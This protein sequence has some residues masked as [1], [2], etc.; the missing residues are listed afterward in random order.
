MQKYI[1]ILKKLVLWAIILAVLAL[2]VFYFAQDF[3]TFPGRG[4]YAGNPGEWQTRVGSLGY[5]GFIP[6]DFLGAGGHA[7][8]GIWAPCGPTPGPAILWLHSREQTTTEINQNIKPL[9]QAGLHVFAM[10]FRGYGAST[11]ETKEANLLADGETSIEWMGRHELIAGKRVFVG[12]LGLGAN[13]AL[14]LASRNSVHGVIA[15]NPLPDMATGIAAQ[16][17]FVPLGFLL[18]ENFDLAPALSAVSAPVFIVHG[19][20]DRVVSL[21]RIEEIV[22]KLAVS[23]RLREVPGAGHL[24]A[25][26]RGGSGLSEEIAY[27]KD[28]PR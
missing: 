27:F 3:M 26:E 14:K 2:V 24:D 1:Q 21:Q 28:R 9:T 13:L 4:L 7:V 6:V 12:G 17:P 5:Q 19:T 20:E 11:G 10:E 15:V 25:L 16:I 22:A 8:K 18:K 23:V